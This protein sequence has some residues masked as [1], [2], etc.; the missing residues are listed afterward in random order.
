[1]IIRVIAE[2]PR[3]R[4]NTA[5]DLVVY[6]VPEHSR[7]CELL[8]ELFESAGIQYTTMEPIKKLKTSKK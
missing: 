8:F 5:S 2:D 4:P 6:Q 7:E 3:P 1:M